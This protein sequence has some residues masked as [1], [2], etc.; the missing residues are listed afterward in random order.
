MEIIDKNNGKSYVLKPCSDTT[1]KKFS[2][3]CLILELYDSH[4]IININML[5]LVEGGPISFS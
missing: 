3:N 4:N 5:Y 2:L 1:C